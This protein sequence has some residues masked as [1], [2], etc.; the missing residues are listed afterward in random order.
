MKKTIKILML[1][2]VTC[3]AITSCSKDDEDTF[4]ITNVTGLPFY[5]CNVWFMD[6]KGG[7]L[8]N[9]EK[10]GNLLNNET[11]RV[12]KQGLFFNIDARNSSGKLILSNDIMVSDK[13]NIYKSN[14]LIY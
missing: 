2:L 11:V 7:E 3:L 13:V 8:T 10:V 5:D 4:E 9:Y 1:L 12:K 14:L 6:S